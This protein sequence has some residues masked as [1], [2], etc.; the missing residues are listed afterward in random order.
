M[1]FGTQRDLQ[2]A[3]STQTSHHDA[4]PDFAVGPAPRPAPVPAAADEQPVDID[5]MSVGL[6][7][8]ALIAVGGLVPFWM[9]IYFVYN[10]PIK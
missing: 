5:W 8:L 2:T 4:P 3:T 1:K 6:G 7:L 9:W 10:P